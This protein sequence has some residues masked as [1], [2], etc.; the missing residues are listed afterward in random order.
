MRKILFSLAA[1]CAMQASWAQSVNIKFTE[2][3][4]P[5]GL[6][7]ILHEDHTVPTVAVSVLYHVGS[8][9]KTLLEQALPTFSNIFCL[10]EVKILLVVNT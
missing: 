4:L 1:L 6:H 8:K 5:N 10:R 2:Y 9:M 7:V 3:D